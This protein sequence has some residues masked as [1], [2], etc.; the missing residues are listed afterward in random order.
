MGS[1]KYVTPVLAVLANGSKA[2]KEISP[3]CRSLPVQPVISF[4]VKTPP[5]SCKVATG[6]SKLGFIILIAA[7]CAL[8]QK[9]YLRQQYQRTKNFWIS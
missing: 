8:L 9:N 5:L 6:F 4:R 7:A 3:A 1:F 2:P